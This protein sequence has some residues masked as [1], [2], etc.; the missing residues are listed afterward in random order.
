LVKQPEVPARLGRYTLGQKPGYQE[1]ENQKLKNSMKKE[2]LSYIETALS[3]I[4]DNQTG[5]D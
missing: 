4:Y 1:L 5:V 2:L 3:A